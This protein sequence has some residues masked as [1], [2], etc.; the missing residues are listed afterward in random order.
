MCKRTFK[1]LQL[2]NMLD[3]CGEQHGFCKSCFSEYFENLIT[4]IQKCENLK[5]PF[6]SCQNYATND[7]VEGAVSVETF[8][9]FLEL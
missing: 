4:G 5:C 1:R 8:E 7:D 6:E 9:A 2:L 3:Q